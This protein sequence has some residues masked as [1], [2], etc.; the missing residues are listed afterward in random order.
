MPKLCVG[1]PPTFMNDI[2]SGAA[3]DSEDLVMVA[4]HK[5]LDARDKL[6]ILSQDSQYDLACACGSSVAD[7]RKRSKDDKWIYPV[8][9]PH[10]NSFP[11]IIESSAHWCGDIHTCGVFFP[12]AAEMPFPDVSGAVPQSFKDVSDRRLS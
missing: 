4:I 3:R 10:L 7:Q 8:T 5:G 6:E 2:P 9:M 12:S 1:M 11:E